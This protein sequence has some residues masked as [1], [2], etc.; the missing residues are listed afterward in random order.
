[1]NP[2]YILL[3]LT[4]VILV[5]SC[6]TPYFK[7]P[8]D[9]RNMHATIYLR[10]GKSFD[11]RMNV[12]SKQLF[13][14]SIKLYQE[15]D[16]KPMQ[17]RFEQIKGYSIR[18]DY[19]ALKRMNGSS[20]FNMSRKYSF[21]RRLTPESSLI[22]LYENVEEETTVNRSDNSR[23][24]EYD[25]QYYLE[26][27][28]EETDAVWALTSS[29]FVP[30]FDDKMSKLVS[31]CPVLARKIASKEEGYFYAQVS[32]IKEK[33]AGVL[34]NIIEDYNRCKRSE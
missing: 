4:M 19:Y 30:N 15:G 14:E 6:G 17:F 16:K 9:L 32:L 2:K 7:T 34:L 1:M 27:P 12:N 26:L 29:R 13:G 18:G 28:N 31:D 24:T 22:H 5:S 11:G 10:D 33:R 25:L 23:R 8:N 21:M 20:L 3:F